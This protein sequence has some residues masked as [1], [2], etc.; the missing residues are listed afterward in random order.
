MNKER[1]KKKN[2]REEIKVYQGMTY[3]QK[4]NQIWNWKKHK[5]FQQRLLSSST[6][7]LFVVSKIKSLTSGGCVSVVDPSC[8]QDIGDKSQ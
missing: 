4:E 2:Q 5:L 6:F 3:H 1:E 7:Q 8:L